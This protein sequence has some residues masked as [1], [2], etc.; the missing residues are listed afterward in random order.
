VGTDR[1]RGGEA[2]D[3]GLDLDGARIVAWNSAKNRV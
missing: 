2:G 1:V 3:A